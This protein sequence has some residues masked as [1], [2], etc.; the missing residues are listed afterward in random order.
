M[1]DELAKAYAEACAGVSERLVKCQRLLQQGLRSEAIQLAEVQPRL[2]DAVASLDFP[3]RGAWDEVVQMYG[4]PE[5]ARFRV[6]VAAFLNEAYA[7]E[8][9]LQDLLRTHRRLALRAAP[10]EARIGVM[11]K[12]ATQDPNNPVWTEDLRIFEKVR[13]RQIQVEAADAAKRH[14]VGALGH[15]LGELEEQKWE[16]PPPEALVQGVRK[17]DA[18]FRGQQNLA[19]LAD[20]ESQLN[21]AFSSSNPVEAPRTDRWLTMVRSLQLSPRDPI[22]AVWKRL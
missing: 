22:H 16:E 18:L 14:D 17:T 10:S 9:P 19:I 6:E 20:L 7:E 5:A 11:R 3:E 8:D 4:L 21:D 15:L 2:L 12:L 1:L 13:F